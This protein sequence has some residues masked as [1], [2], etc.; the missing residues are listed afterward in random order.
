M[1]AVWPGAA[2]PPATAPPL[3]PPWT[4]LAQEAGQPLGSAV[5]LQGL[6]LGPISLLGAPLEIF[7]AIKE[8]VKRE[9]RSQVTLVLGLTNG[10]IGY[11]PDRETAAKGGYAVD[12]VPLIV[13]E[14]PFRDIHTE[15][16]RELLL[17]EADLRP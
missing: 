4:D 6:R 17:V 8:D 12:T 15:L 13:G 10:D 7:R 14:L 9:A 11:A 1:G 2:R 5:E 3:S 16:V